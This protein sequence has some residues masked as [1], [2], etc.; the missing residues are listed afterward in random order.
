MLI[1]YCEISIEI[2]GNFII[3]RFFAYLFMK[4]LEF[5]KNYIIFFMKSLLKINLKKL[6]VYSSLNFINYTDFHR[7]ISK[8]Q[9]IKWS[10]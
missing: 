7:I 1:L 10:Y 4:L 5:E 3:I 8:G 2:I 6:I 9:K